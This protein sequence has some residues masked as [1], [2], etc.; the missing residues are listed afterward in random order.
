MAATAGVSHSQ[1]SFK[2]SSPV[3]AS[4][5]L[6]SGGAKVSGLVHK[7][8]PQLHGEG[9]YEQLGSVYERIA[10]YETVG[11]VYDDILVPEVG[12]HEASV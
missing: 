12:F 2:L 11:N 6:D 5:T 4:R 7:K 9:Q 3:H 8:T 10:T 1:E